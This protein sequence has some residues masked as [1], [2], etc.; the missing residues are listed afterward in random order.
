MN[1]EVQGPDVSGFPLAFL[2][3]FFANMNQRTSIDMKHVRRS[4]LPL[5][6]EGSSPYSIGKV[7][8]VFRKS[9]ASASDS[10]GKYSPI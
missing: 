10:L 6:S 4:D 7:D 5:P 9:I 1:V 2:T 8:S 3:S